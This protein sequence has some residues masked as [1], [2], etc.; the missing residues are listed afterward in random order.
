MLLSNGSLNPRL[1]QFLSQNWWG[2]KSTDTQTNVVLVNNNQDSAQ[3]NQ[4]V[5]DALISSQDNL[6]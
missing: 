2:M 6:D 3:H 4:D 1:Y 5:L